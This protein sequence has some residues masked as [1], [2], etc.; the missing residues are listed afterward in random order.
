MGLFSWSFSEHSRP[1]FVLNAKH[2]YQSRSPRNL[3]SAS[4][5]IK[6][7]SCK[8]CGI[9]M[10][11]KCS[12][13]GIFL[14]ETT[15][16]AGHVTLMLRCSREWPCDPHKRGKQGRWGKYGRCLK[17]DFHEGIAACLVSMDSER[18]LFS[19]GKKGRHP[20]KNRSA[21]RSHATVFF[22]YSCA[23]TPSHS[24]ERT[25][26][27]LSICFRA[28]KVWIVSLQVGSVVIIEQS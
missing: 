23:G 22:L 4:K 9:F 11:E 18:P 10:S 14:I 15:R 25:L 2:Y 6:V 24:S 5:R 27:C 3:Q 12:F 21:L 13:I 19:F 8:T 26:N 17:N 1:H 16:N 20:P 28:L 7:P